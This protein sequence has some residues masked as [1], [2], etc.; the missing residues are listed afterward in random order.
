MKH[1]TLY[2]TCKLMLLVT[3]LGV[4]G[5]GDVWSQ[6]PSW[7]QQN[8]LNELTNN[9]KAKLWELINGYREKNIFLPSENELDQLFNISNS[10]W[11][12]EKYAQ[13]GDKYVLDISYS[14]TN[15]SAWSQNVLNSANTQQI[16]LINRNTTIRGNATKVIYARPNEPKTIRFQDSRTGAENVDGFI[17]WYVDSDESASNNP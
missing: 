2:N 13:E 15:E 11:T 7:D 10:N 5:V 12:Q 17:H 3:V 8:A 16:T 1:Y 6:G 14:G 9:K 4:L